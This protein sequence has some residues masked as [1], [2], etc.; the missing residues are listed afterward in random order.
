MTGVFDDKEVANVKSNVQYC[1]YCMTPIQDGKICPRCGLTAGNYVPQPHHLRPGTLL[2]DRYLVGRVL[3]EG[4]FGIT[5]IGCDLRLELKVAIKEYYPVDKVSRNTAVSEQLVSFS[6]TPARTGFARGKARFLEEARTMAKMEKQQVIVGVRDFFETNNTAYIVMEYIEGTTFTELVA[7]RG[8]RIPPEELFTLIEPLFN[9]LANLHRLGLIHRDISPDNL[10]L[11]DGEVRLIDFGCARDIERGNETLTITL[12][13]GYAPIEQYQTSGGQGPWTDVYALCATIYFC[14]VGQKP[15]QA[16]NRIGSEKSLILPSKLGI[17]ISPQREAAIIHGLNLSPKNRYQTMEELK[18]ALYQPSE[19]NQKPNPA[20]DIETSSEQNSKPDSEISSGSDEKQES[21]PS[22]HLTEI[23]RQS[24]SFIQHHILPIGAGAAVLVLILT[25]Q[26]VSGMNDLS[27]NKD[28]NVQPTV[29]SLLQNQEETTSAQSTDFIWEDA[30]LLTAE[31]MTL[32]GLQKLMEDSSVKSL[33]LPK[34]VSGQIGY[35]S[36]GSLFTLTKPMQIQAGAELDVDALCIDGEGFLEVKGNVIMDDCDLRMKGEQS[37]IHFPDGLDGHISCERGS[38]WMESSM[39]LDSADQIA[40]KNNGGYPLVFKEEMDKAREVTNISELYSCMNEEIPQGIK[41]TKDI[42]LVKEFSFAYPIYICEGVTVSAASSKQNEPFNLALY[43]DTAVLINYG[44][45]AAGVWTDSG[46]SFLNFGRFE[47]G[48]DNDVGN[49][50]V[51][52]SENSYSLILNEGY[53]LHQ[54]CSRLWESNH[55]LNTPTGT[56]E[57][58]N[59]FLLNASLSNYGA[60]SLTGKQDSLNL[61]TGSQ[62]NNFGTLTITENSGM[63]NNGLLYNKGSLLAESGSKLWNGY[64]VKN[65]FGTIRAES[66]AQLWGSPGFL[67]EPTS[68]GYVSTGGTVELLCSNAP[69]VYFISDKQQMDEI[70]ASASVAKTPEQLESLLNDGSVEAIIIAD[71]LTYTGECKVSKNLYITGNLTVTDGGLVAVGNK[72]ILADGGSLTADNISLLDG[73]VMQLNDSTLTVQEGGLLDL[74]S[75]MIQGSGNSRLLAAGSDIQLRNQSLII[76]ES[77]CNGEFFSMDNSHLSIE[78]QSA[79]VMPT[80]SSMTVLSGVV[81]DLENARFSGGNNLMLRNCTVNIGQ[82]GIFTEYG[83]DLCLE[84]STVYIE[85]E[86]VMQSELCNILLRDTTITNDGFFFISGWNEIQF[87][88][89]DSVIYNNGNAEI[90][91]PNDLIGE[92]MI[93]NK[94]VLYTSPD[95]PIDSE[96]IDGNAQKTS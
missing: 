16:L 60:I 41:I 24:L 78:G 73:A 23:L 40:I 61:N 88:Q 71:D 28:N 10:M 8:G 52:L 1:P 65:D 9:A 46:A 93:Y 47:G 12:K 4:G 90:C 26:F 69:P 80:G 67:D 56:L 81:M 18:G 83:R 20:P 30:Y 15:P 79:M 17:D 22:S 95:H 89:Q 58:E 13:H 57:A 72:V 68:S 45:C 33:I 11:E 77:D 38:F 55:L 44:T 36:D 34:G 66:G 63:R 51:W 49:S 29:N 70:A 37:R 74:D 62:L 39:N 96:R 2:M 6:V 19:I 48:P 84:N 76:P 86:A 21:E 14:L 27:E 5:Y 82:G 50:S 92:S 43:A 94:G 42:T 87:S 75:S 64:L 53:M 54:D 7:Q 91:L 35:L 32:E 85:K 31:D 59:F 3:G 25:A